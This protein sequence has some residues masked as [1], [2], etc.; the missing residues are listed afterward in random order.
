[1]V[2][3]IMGQN[4]FTLTKYYRDQG[5]S[6]AEIG[7]LL[8]NKGFAP[9]VVDECV[10]SIKRESVTEI[11]RRKKEARKAKPRKINRGLVVGW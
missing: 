4:P 10:N 7:A 2:G 6:P 11:E 5:R 9:C 1:M 8:D 3:F